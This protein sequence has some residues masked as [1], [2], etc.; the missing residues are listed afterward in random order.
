MRLEGFGELLRHWL[1][2]PAMEIDASVHTER[3]HSLKPLHARLQYLRRIQPPNIFRSIHLNRPKPLRQ[4]FFRSTLNIARS[5]ATIQA[6]TFTL[7]RTLPSQQLPNR[8]IEFARFQIPKSDIDASE[9]GHEDWA[10]AVERFPPG[11]LPECFD[12]VGFVADEA[13]DVAVEG[14]FD[15]FGVA[16]I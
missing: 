13:G 3:L 11:I 2:Q 10:A 7:S 15:G 1:V 8:Y 4:T 14:A 12:V 6:Y 5:V 9:S 16:L